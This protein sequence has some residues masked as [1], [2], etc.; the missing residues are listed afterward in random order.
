MMAVQVLPIFLLMARA[1][2]AAWCQLMPAAQLLYR[3]R[4]W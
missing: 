3:A 1:Q 4:L 2:A